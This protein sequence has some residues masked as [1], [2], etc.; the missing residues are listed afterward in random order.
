MDFGNFGTTKTVPVMEKLA[1]EITG[2]NNEKV[3]IP[4]CIAVQYFPSY[5]DHNLIQKPWL[6]FAHN[7]QS[8]APFVKYHAAL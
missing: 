5:A 6:L 8:G 1:N 7:L 4:S 3:D 2:C